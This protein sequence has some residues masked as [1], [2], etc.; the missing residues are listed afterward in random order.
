MELVKQ[1]SQDLNKLS[2][3]KSEYGAYQGF[4]YDTRRP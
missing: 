3:L 2:E 4:G 1:I